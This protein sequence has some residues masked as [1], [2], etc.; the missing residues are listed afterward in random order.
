MCP[1]RRA[2]RLLNMSNDLGS[3]FGLTTF[4]V[5]FAWIITVIPIMLLFY[6]VVRVAISRGLRDHQLWMEKHRPNAALRAPDAGQAPITPPPTNAGYFPA[7]PE[8]RH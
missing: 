7:P 8:R 6:G 4:G 5:V 3:W 1:S 2:E